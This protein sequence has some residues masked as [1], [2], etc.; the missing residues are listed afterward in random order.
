LALILLVGVDLRVVMLAVPPVIPAIHR[1]L[2]LDEKGIAALSSLPVLV[3][4]LAAVPGSLLIARLGAR[5]ALL[6]GLVVVAF[7]GAARG[8]VP[9]A[10]L[11]FAM[12][13]LMGVGI[14]VSQ[15][16]AP[17]VVKDWF[18]AQVGLA[19]A[20]YANGVLLGE[21]MPVTLAP[22]ILTAVRNSWGLSLALWSL[23]VVFT[24]AAIAGLTPGHGRAPGEPLAPW[25]PDWKSWRTWQAGLLL[26]C[27]SALYWSANAF[28]PDLLHTSGRLS[29]VT[30][31]LAVLNAAQ[32]PISV[33]IT[34]APSRFV[35]HRWPFLLGGVTVALA[36]PAMVLMPG[37]WVVFWAA[38]LG[39][40]SG[41]VFVCALALP[42]LLSEPRDVARL[43][44]AMFTITYALSFTGPLLGGAAWDAT[45]VPLSAFV[46]ATLAGLAMVALAVRL[47]LGPAPGD[48]TRQQTAARSEPTTTGSSGAG[49][50]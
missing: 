29:L 31:A 28:L 17:S 36:V 26:G 35:G 45:G 7:A 10:G 14:A 24:V 3:L 16:A 22:W 2:A 46:P 11:L 13:F 42:P 8:L 6:A 21:I 40:V 37:A 12:T 50:V 19:T 39:A 20:M 48:S 15:P 9:V 44:A 18:P 43:S 33:L 1:D 41:L 5:R 23:P 49:E 27:M 32:L 30:P 47:R 34:L 38:I 25:W 4:A